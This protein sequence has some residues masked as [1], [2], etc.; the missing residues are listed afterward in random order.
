MA[1]VRRTAMGNAIDMDRIRLSN[2]KTIAIGNAKV[3]ARGDKLGPGGKVVKTKA[4]IMAEYYK[5]HTPTAQTAP[6]PTDS[7]SQLAEDEIITPTADLAQP[8]ALP[9]PEV[10]VSPEYVKPRGSFADAIAKDTEVKQE[11]V[12]PPGQ[13]NKGV[14]RI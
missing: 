9:D 12:T 3:N 4:E 7:S 2:E 13:K 10:D 11:L 8:V 1:D 5:L 14:S 6:T